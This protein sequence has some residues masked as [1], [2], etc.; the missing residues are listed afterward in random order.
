MN[1]IVEIKELVGLKLVN[2]YLLKG[3]VYLSSFHVSNVGIVFLLG[4]KKN[5]N[6]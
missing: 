2:D 1:D 4:R 6:L 5:R 3:W